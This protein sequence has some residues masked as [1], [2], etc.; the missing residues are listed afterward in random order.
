MTSLEA[1]QALHF[2]DG[3]AIRRVHREGVL[4]L[5]GPRA[6]LMQLAH[7]GVAQGV[8]EH[9]AFQ[10]D[11]LGRLLRT[12]RLTLAMAFGSP[13]RAEDAAR[14]IR[15]RHT[16]VAGAGYDASDPDLL[17][18]VWAT[19]VDTSLEMQARFLGPLAPAEA[20]AY[21]DDMRRIGEALGIP[22]SRLPPDVSSFHVY[23]ESAIS[24]LEV[25]P[26][27][28]R[29]ASEVFESAPALRPAMLALRAFTAATLPPRLRDALG[30]QPPRLTTLL[31]SAVEPASRAVLPRLPLRLRR[32]PSF[33]LPPRD[34]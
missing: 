6:L 8:A 31:L 9:S 3:S 28:R 4:L 23:V 32:T 16:T 15:R 22:P 12:L 34:V 20:E 21:L 27:G 5:G 30:L 17:L 29:L 2:S 7:P 10:T 24:R 11:R 18:W 33:L 26:T 14:S 13:R 1:P 19:L 25:S